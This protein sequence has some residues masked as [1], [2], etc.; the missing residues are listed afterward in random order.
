MAGFKHTVV[1]EICNISFEKRSGKKQASRFCSR[2]CYLVW[3]AN[4]RKVDCVC[5]S[6]NKAFQIR[7]SH[8]KNGGG[9]CCS[10]ACRVAHKRP[11]SRECRQCGY[12]FSPIE[13]RQGTKK[14]LIIVDN[15]RVICS[16]KCLNQFYR[17]NEARK[18]K[19]SEAFG[20]KKHPMWK[21]GLSQ[22]NRGYRGPHWRMIRR[23]VRKLQK[24]CC[25]RCGK[26]EDELG[27][28][29]DVNHIEPWHNFT[30]HRKANALSNLEGLCKS[31]H[32]AKEQRT[33]VQ[34]ALFL[35]EGKKGYSGSRCY[36]AK[37]STQQIMG[38][39]SLSKQG[40]TTKDIAKQYNVSHQ[41]IWGIVT[42]RTYKDV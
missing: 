39:R 15:S 14:L 32:M 40:I 31:C 42:N 37:F 12:L 26:H 3:H 13:Y 19:I 10:W 28:A 29:L 27:Q 33:N 25:A 24:H 9:Q 2:A 22:G 41:V 11:K 34:L 6:C 4:H 8:T 35:G 5:L 38:I 18:L 1:C 7:R 30:D 21:G 36:Q 23:K 20:G 16:E 17:T